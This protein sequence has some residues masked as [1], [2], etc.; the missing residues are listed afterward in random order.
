MIYQVRMNKRLHNIRVYVTLKT[1]GRK[2]SAMTK[3][4]MRIFGQQ[5]KSEEQ[6]TAA[7]KL[8]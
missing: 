4:F 5:Q 7:D 2:E 6:Q 8:R 1:M 3:L